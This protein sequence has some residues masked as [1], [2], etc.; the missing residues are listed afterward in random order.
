E[1]Q[2][3]VGEQRREVL[4]VRAASSQRGVAAVDRVHLDQTGVLLVATGRTN[5]AGEVI[6]LA[7]PVLAGELEGDVGV[8][9]ARQVRLDA[10]EA[11]PLVADVEIAG[12]V[13]GFVRLALD[14]DDL[15]QVDVLAL[16]TVLGV[17]ALAPT[18]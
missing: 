18:P 11:V 16:R 12:D 4:E 2:P 15:D 9:L 13:D 1:R 7:Q 5:L 3:L 17:A 14:T 8:V 10:Q 6:A